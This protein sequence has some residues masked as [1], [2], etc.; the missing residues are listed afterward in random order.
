MASI[1]EICNLALSNIRAGSINSL[2]EASLAA[3][4]CDL[5]YSYMRDHVLRDAPWQFARKVDALALTTIDSFNWSYTYAYPSDCLKINRL[6]LNIEGVAAGTNDTVSRYYRSGDPRIDL[7]TAVE[8]EI[9][10]ASGEKVIV[11]NDAQLRADYVSRVEDPNLYD[12]QFILA[13]SHLLAAELAIPLAGADLGS[14]LRK[15]NFQLY[16][17]YINAALTSDFNEQ[18]KDTADSDFITVRN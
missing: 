3:Q 15:E 16:Q 11:A 14:A 6:L 13:L 17:N 4:Q 10:N 2:T 1:V 18:H 9:Q 8:Y 5:K 7:Q 12:D